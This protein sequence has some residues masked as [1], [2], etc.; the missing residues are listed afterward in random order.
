MALRAGQEVGVETIEELT[1]QAPLLLPES[2]GVALQVSV[3]GPGEEG[4]RE[5]AIHSRTET[6]A[7]MDSQP[8]SY[9]PRACSRPPVRPRRTPRT[10]A[11]L[12]C[13]AT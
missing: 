4:E 10:V 13:R 9:T 2:G 5:V 12:G 6:G 7:D 1:L 11:A 3:S 8:W